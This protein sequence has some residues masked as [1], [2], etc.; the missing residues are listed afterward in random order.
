MIS[1]FKPSTNTA[2]FKGAAHEVAQRV[3]DLQTDVTAGEQKKICANDLAA[4]VV[5]R[6]GGSAGCEAALKTQVAEVDNAEAIVESVQ[7]NG[8]NATAKVKSTYSGKKKLGTVALLKEGKQWKI[9]SL[10]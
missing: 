8:T 2:K 1:V 6:L 5:K 10:Q 9:S 7:V 4:D 3:A